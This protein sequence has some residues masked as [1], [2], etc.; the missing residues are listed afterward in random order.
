MKKLIGKE[1][2]MTKLVMII[3]IT[4]KS[5]ILSSLSMKEALNLMFNIQ[6]ITKA[7]YLLIQVNKKVK[8]KLLKI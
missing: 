4:S 7:K 1:Q 8:N 2:L 5:L 6:K 3:L